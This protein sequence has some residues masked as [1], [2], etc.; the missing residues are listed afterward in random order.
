MS[1][2]YWLWFCS[3]GTW[4]DRCQLIAFG[5]G[6]DKGFIKAL[7]SEGVK[8]VKRFIEKGGSYLGMC[9]GAY[10]AC[11]Y[12]EFDKD[13]PL[14]VVGKRDLHF[15]SGMSMILI[16][17]WEKYSLA[18]IDCELMWIQSKLENNFF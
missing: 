4:I 16:V 8:N 17:W 1:L 6:Y 12:I 7:G 9:A 2:L 5:G 3:S 15:F 13:G 10:F 11:D 14:E 18:L